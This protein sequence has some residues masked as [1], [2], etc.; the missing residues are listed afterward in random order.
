MTKVGKYLVQH[1]SAFLSTGDYSFLRPLTRA[2]VAQSIDVHESTVSRA[3]SGKFVQI[4]NG[5]IVAFDVFFKGSLRAQKMIEEIL[6]TEN[7]G[8]PLSDARISAMLAERGVIVAR[9][10][11]SKYRDRGK[12]LSSR[13]RRVA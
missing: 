12:N 11:V 1:Q 4:V 2:K 3:T 8:N 13:K 6:Q 10:T 9:R 5:E 7:P